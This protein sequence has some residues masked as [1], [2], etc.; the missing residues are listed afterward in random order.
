MNNALGM[1]RLIVINQPPLLWE[2]WGFV[3]Y[4]RPAVPAGA[5]TCGQYSGWRP[6]ETDVTAQKNL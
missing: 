5:G 3:F 6:E 1:G 2:A 4:R